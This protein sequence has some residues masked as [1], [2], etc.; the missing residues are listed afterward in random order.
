MKKYLLFLLAFLPMVVFTACS[1]DDDENQ[2]PE[3][4]GTWDLDNATGYTQSLTFAPDGA[5]LEYTTLE[6]TNAKMEEKGTYSVNKDKLTITWK[7]SRYYNFFSDKWTNFEPLEKGAETVV[8][9]FTIKDKTLTFV[10]MEGEAT[11]S[12]TY[13]TRK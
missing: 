1:S 11:F 13:Y 6:G 7:E 8:I 10:S 9:T 12:P 5:V 3:I 2:I 4:I